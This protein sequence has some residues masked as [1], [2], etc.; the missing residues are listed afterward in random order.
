MLEAFL[1][2]PVPPRLYAQVFEFTDRIGHT[3]WRLLDPEHPR[4]DAELAE[5]YG[6]EML[7]AYQ[8]MDEIVGGAMK[9]LDDR[10]LLLVVSDH[11]FG[12][13]RHAVNYNTWLIREGYM[14]LYGM[15]S[16]PK[17]LE[18]LFGGG[19]FFENVDWS[20]TKAYAM[21]LGN[22]YINL[23]GREPKGIVS[24]G[25]EYENVRDEII[26]KLEA[27]MDEETGLHPVH[28][29]Y[30]REDI[31]R[32]FD[33]NAPDLR[34]ANRPPFRV[35]WQTSLGGAPKRLTETNNKKWS[36]DHCSLD[37]ELVKGIF[38][39]SRPIASPEPR[40]IDVY[41]TV[42]EALGLPLPDTPGKNVLA[43]PS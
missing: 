32:S 16:G 30:R 5:R 1:D 29:V 8:K 27:W 41:P 42:L 34:A 24:L 2:E 28:R 25:E 33:P 43:A 10:T 7:R 39:S 9:K 19:E 40:I 15:L 23:R 3:F 36:A 22:I 13:W 17:N 14:T 38:F 18:D 20:R 6:G 37:P 35:S 12:T 31:Y 11:G 21:G 4:Y 26:E